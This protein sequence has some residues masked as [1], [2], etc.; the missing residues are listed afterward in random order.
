MNTLGAT[1]IGVHYARTEDIAAAGVEG[2]AVGLGIS[3]QI[4]NAGTN[5]YSQLMW[6]DADVSSPSTQLESVVTFLV[7]AQVKF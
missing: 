4:K 6:W 7:G 2:Q 3:Q 5:L 1:G